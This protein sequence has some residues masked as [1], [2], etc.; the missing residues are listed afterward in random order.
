M[1]RL[2]LFAGLVGAL[3]LASWSPARADVYV[4]PPSLGRIVYG[5][6]GGAVVLPA[7]AWQGDYPDG[8]GTPLAPND[9]GF[10]G[11]AIVVGAQIRYAGD[12]VG[13]GWNFTTV[14]GAGAVNAAAVTPVFNP[15]GSA[16][17]ILSTKLGFISTEG[18]NSTVSAYTTPSIS[19]LTTLF[20]ANTNAGA[21]SLK[22]VTNPVGLAYTSAI[23]AFAYY[24][25][26]PAN[27]TGSAANKLYNHIKAYQADASTGIYAGLYFVGFEDLNFEPAGSKYHR[28]DY[29][30]TVIQ[31]SFE[32]V[33][34][35]AFYQMAGLLSLG[36]FGLLRLRRR[37]AS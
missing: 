8:S 36:A 5:M 24:S 20:A 23:D 29:N 37:S 10:A 1:K 15:G 26:N 21:T 7:D 3:A 33:P 14:G 18:W 6:T 9:A 17:K 16:S 28:F 32:A 2:L 35:P 25:D 22:T 34:E 12:A 27:N 11:G 31:M 19:P 30:D 4:D 13:A